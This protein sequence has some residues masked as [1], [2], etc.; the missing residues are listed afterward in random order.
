MI[1]QYSGSIGAG[2]PSPP[3]TSPVSTRT[4]CL[5]MQ[6]AVASGAVSAA[7]G[8]RPGTL[9][10]VTALFANPYLGGKEEALIVAGNG[11]LTYLQRDA[12]D[13]GWLQSTVTG[14]G[15]D[16][17]K[18]TEVVV[19]IHPQDLTVWA[20]YSPAAAGPPRAMRLVAT[21][22]GAET[23]CAWVEQPG[24]ISPGSGPAVSGLH[25]MYVYYDVRSPLITAL[26]SKS[27]SIV[28]ILISV[29]NASRFHTQVYPAGFASGTANDLVAGRVASSPT[30]LHPGAPIV[31][32][33]LGSKIVRYDASS[34]KEPRVIASDATDLLG[35]YRAYGLPDVG[36]LYL[37]SSGNLVAWN[38]VGGNTTA[39]SRTP[40]LGLVTATVW[41]DVNQMAHVYGLDS[42][43]GL[44]VLHQTAIGADGLPVWAQAKTPDP[45]RVQGG[46]VYSCVGLVP[47]V[48][49][50]AVDPFPD[51]QPNELVKRAG[52]A[53][54]DEQYSF[55]TQ[56]IASARWS[57]D[58][59]RLPSD[60]AP[61]LVSHYVSSVTLLDEH[62]IGMPLL[63]V[64][65][66]A[67]TLTEIQVDGSSYLVGPGHSAS[68]VTGPTG[69][70]TIATAAGSLLP[71]TL[72]VDAVG[73]ANGAVVQPAAAVHA[74]LA[75]TG[76][77]PSQIGLFDERALSEARFDGAPIVD[78]K[79]RAGIGG[80]VDS[81]HQIFSRAAGRPLASKLYRGPGPASPIH[82]FYF[83]PDPADPAA[84][85]GGPAPS[86]QEFSTPDCAAAHLEALRSLPQYGGIWDDFADWAG[87][88]AE[89]ITNGAIE[90]FAVLIDTVA[91]VFIRIGEKF[92]EAVGFAI[93]T[94]AGALL[95]VEAV[96]AMVVV[97]I[98]AVLG[99]LRSPF[100]FKHV[101]DTK[102]AMEEGFSMMLSYGTT[103]VAGVKK[104]TDGWF[105]SQEEAVL[106]C[107]EGL[108]A[109]YH[110]RALGDLANQVPALTD[111]SGRAVAPAALAGDPQATW[112][113]DQMLA[114]RHAACGRQLR[115]EVNPD[116]TL[117]KGF[118][119]FVAAFEKSEIPARYTAALKD[120][121]AVAEQIASAGDPDAVQK[122][123]L[124]ALIDLLEQLTVIALDA[125]DLFIGGILALVLQV[126]ANIGD[127]LNA[128]VDFGPADTLYGWI[129]EKAY[130]GRPVEKLTLG[131]LIFL[132][133]AF[134]ATSA[135]KRVNGPDSE[136][137]P[138]G[139]FPKVPAPPGHPAYRGP[140][141]F[142]NDPSGNADLKADQ[143]NAGIFAI[144]G[145]VS[146]FFN[147]LTPLMYPRVVPVPPSDP[148]GARD[149][150]WAMQ[151]LFAGP[152][153]VCSEFLFGMIAASP[154]VNGLQWDAAGGTWAWAFIS[155]TVYACF[156][157]LNFLAWTV[158]MSDS[159]ALKNNGW[160][161]FGT[162]A[163]LLGG[164]AYLAPAAD[165][166]TRSG[167]IPYVK[168]QI[169]MAALADLIQPLRVKTVAEDWTQEWRTV[170]GALIDSG[171]LVASGALLLYPAKS[172]AP[173]IP[174]NQTLPEGRVGV[175]YCAAIT[176]DGGTEWFNRPLQKWSATIPKEW[177]EFTLD[178]DTG[179]IHGTPQKSG[180]V[181]LRNIEV[182]DSYAPPQRSG[183]LNRLRFHIAP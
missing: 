177:R 49:A 101:W 81:T 161:V 59:V 155:Q 71:A 74:Y 22:D 30:H 42:K 35:V 32:V 23:T 36:C 24:A 172:P 135:I 158:G 164:I 115:I 27:G 112:L 93:G 29:G 90:V 156:T 56:D 133:S 39:V 4:D 61:H 143:F 109:Q 41:L 166:A 9:A 50:F 18:A 89:G 86:Y 157:G 10:G 116:S 167:S 3:F 84:A 83:G 154:P 91:T 76:T 142:G 159:A 62:G 162:F 140:I 183:K 99:W 7:P 98:P 163:A 26:D 37:D 69:T 144:I 15:K 52:T 5:L 87:D 70:V 51:S 72:H 92:I 147:D 150:R 180:W 145:S 136:P 34:A 60:A 78:E 126:E 113:R 43:N 63:P 73:L 134:G 2:P 97:S 103:V 111:A 114:P 131:G 13:T 104:F 165:G 130:P 108:K 33:R 58:K 25:H 94:I 141:D 6:D 178:P 53:R 173:S 153:V 123:D 17:I 152:A 16:P 139:R 102:T 149:P 1:N 168:A 68:L 107:F 67:G 14:G 38:E 128:K 179:V 45:A 44:K 125:M 11:A 20:V 82:G 66:S 65:V 160:G 48:A 169:A 181:E 19:V 100:Y 8:T 151:A 122:A 75:G 21:T 54:P 119:E 95:A 148:S 64:R 118:A 129:Q 124:T 176:G 77:L 88:V 12:T 105:A 132:V 110:G 182:W 146:E 96:L 175:L 28:S 40:G 121:A 106:N 171:A 80:A 170:L 120:V 31:Y 46:T 127:L 47:G 138:D 85:V 79:H 55:Y 57:R 174:P 137:F 117:A